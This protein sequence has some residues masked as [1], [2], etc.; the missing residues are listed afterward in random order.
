MS[1]LTQDLGQTVTARMRRIADPSDTV[2]LIGTLP[3]VPAPQPRHPG[4]GQDTRRGADTT[5]PARRLRLTARGEGYLWG[6]TIVVGATVGTILPR[7]CFEAVLPFLPW[8]G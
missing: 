3:P 5:L 1:T 7:L 6:L 2:V 8:G 4:G